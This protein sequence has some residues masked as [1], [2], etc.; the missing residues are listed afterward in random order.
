VL[1]L[2]ADRGLAEV[3]GH[4]ARKRALKTFGLAEHVDSYEALY[5]QV[6]KVEDKDSDPP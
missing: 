4:N 6:L 5:S 2:I 1:R 3:M